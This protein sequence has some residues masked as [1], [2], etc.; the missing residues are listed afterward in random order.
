MKSRKKFRDDE[1][2]V[3]IEGFASAA[4][5]PGVFVCPAGT[6]LLG[7]HP[8]LR[9]CPGFFVPDGTPTD[10]IARRRS[11]I[12]QDAE[13]GIDPPSAEPQVRTERRIADEDAF[14]HIHSA[15]RVHKDSEAARRS[16]RF[17]PVVPPEL[18]GRDRSEIVIA[19]A[20]MSLADEDGKV[21]RQVFKGQWVARGDAL[22]ALHPSKFEVPTIE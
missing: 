11:Q 2:V 5:G 16:G 9:H 1:V 18:E 6:R 19:T 15:E 22:V 7:N 14:V 10:E 13:A 17:V 4:L 12:Y 20:P 3:C 8:I 21:V